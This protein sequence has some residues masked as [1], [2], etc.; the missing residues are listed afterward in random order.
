MQS[1]E[2]SPKKIE[3]CTT[4]VSLIHRRRLKTKEK[5]NV[6][7]SVW[8]EEFIQFLAALTIFPRTIFEE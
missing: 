4:V 1:A 8:G 2:I 3:D 7:A 6:V 5:A